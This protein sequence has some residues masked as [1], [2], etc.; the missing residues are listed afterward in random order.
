MASRSNNPPETAP[1]DQQIMADFGWPWLQPAIWCSVTEKWV[2]AELNHCEE[3]GKW[4][5]TEWH[6]SFDLR[7]WMP[8]PQVSKP[9]SAEEHF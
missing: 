1:K 2:A 6:S 7:G 8:Y 3:S 9:D 4:F 5:E